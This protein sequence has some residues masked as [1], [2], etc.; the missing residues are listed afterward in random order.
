MEISGNRALRFMEAGKPLRLYPAANSFFQ[1]SRR[2]EASETLQQLLGEHPGHFE[3]HRLMAE[4]ATSQGNYQQAVKHA[5]AAVERR[6]YDTTAHNTLGNA[7]RV[8]GQPEQ[9]KP[10]LQYVAG[11]EASLGRMER[12]LRQVVDDPIN[13][14]LRYEIGMTLLRYGSPVDGLKWL[15]SV[16]E[17]EP[18]H[19]LARAALAGGVR[20]LNENGAQVESINKMP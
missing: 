9:A 8:L 6:P 15:Q 12:Q 14:E 16:L 11:A 1:Q 2:E 5:R 7:L 10:H 3:A 19:Q 13:T 17:I 4:V 20:P 18:E